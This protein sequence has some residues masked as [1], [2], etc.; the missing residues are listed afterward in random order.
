MQFSLSSKFPFFRRVRERVRVR[1]F[2]P[3]AS[4]HDLLLQ[5]EALEGAGTNR[6]L[7]KESQVAETIRKYRGQAA[8][9]N[10]LI[11][12]ISN[13]RAAFTSGRGLSVRWEGKA[14]QQFIAAFL[15]K[16]RIRLSFLRGLARE[17]IFEGQVLLKLDP[18]ADGVPLVRFVSWFDTRYEVEPDALDYGTVRRVE[19]RTSDAWRPFQLPPERCAFMK[20]DTRTHSHTGTPLFAGVLGL[21]EDFDDALQLLKQVNTATAN[22]TPYFR[23]DLADEATAFQNHLQAINWKMGDALAGSGEASILQIGYGPYTAL[24][25][26]VETAAKV[27]SG[28]TSVPAHYFGF[29]DL[30]G[31]RAVADDINTMFVQVAETEVEEWSAGFTDLV[32]RAMAL[33]NQTHG[34]QL[35]TTAGEIL[36]EQISREEFARAVTVWMPLWLGGAITT[37]TLLS[38]IPGVDESTETAKVKAEIE[39][40]ANQQTPGQ[41]V[42]EERKIALDAM[43]TYASSEVT[44]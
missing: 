29:A 14:E 39:A 3:V 8:K 28:H 13:T 19:W 20:F 37:E 32:G 22:P 16:N 23:F 33:Y 30:V 42:P 6:Y 17:R 43:K 38:K 25:Q 21:L 44:G 40:R 26:Q 31:N 10:L 18:Q 7:T 27:L 36:V 41:A 12:N 4:V 15:K 5:I 11:R 24:I 35:N 2:S 1:E 34:V 9:G